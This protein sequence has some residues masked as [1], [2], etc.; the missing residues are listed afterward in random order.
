MAIFALL[1]QQNDLAKI[2]AFLPFDNIP[3]L[4]ICLVR[5]EW[6]NL[7]ISLVPYHMNLDNCDDDQSLGSESTMPTNILTFIRTKMLP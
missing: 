7:Y 6:T 2:I 3:S 1:A 4:C 5:T